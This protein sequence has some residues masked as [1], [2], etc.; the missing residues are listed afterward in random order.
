VQ[1]ELER[2]LIAQ[3]V[4]DGLSSYELAKTLGVSQ[5]TAFRK[6]RKYLLGTDPT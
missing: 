2:D 4:A 5:P 3:A 1:R 6:R